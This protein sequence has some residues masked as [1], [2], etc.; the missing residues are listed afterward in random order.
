MQNHIK[1]E[2]WCSDGGLTFT[3]VDTIN[4]YTHF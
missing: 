1:Q 4:T 3:L 2:A